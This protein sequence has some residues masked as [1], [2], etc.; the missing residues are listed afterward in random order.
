MVLTMQAKSG[1]PM[2]T[3]LIYIWNLDFHF[4]H[5]IYNHNYLAYPMGCVHATL[6]RITD[7][8]VFLLSMKTEEK[9]STLLK[10]KS[11]V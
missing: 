2:P 7:Q 1:K 9:V 10:Q 8:K 11:F 4:I 6:S 3:S 5:L